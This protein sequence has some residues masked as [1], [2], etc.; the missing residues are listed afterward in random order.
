MYTY[1]TS[2]HSR[3]VH[4][5]WLFPFMS[6]YLISFLTIVIACYMFLNACLCL[7][8]QSRDSK[9]P[10]CWINKYIW[11][12]KSY[13]ICLKWRCVQWKDDAA[14]APSTRS[15]ALIWSKWDW[16]EKN[17]QSGTKSTIRYSAVASYTRCTFIWS[18]H[19]L[20]PC[21][22]NA[23]V[24]SLVRIYILTFLCEMGKNTEPSV[25]I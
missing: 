4:F 5:P 16:L 2:T 20:L 1:T 10:N 6:P 14:F 17:V 15:L 8:T 13:E 9:L 21:G 18:C 22:N 7:L 19:V 25:A 24:P 23:L 11:P 3:A 12:I